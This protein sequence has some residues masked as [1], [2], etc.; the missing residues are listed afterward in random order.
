MTS[1]LAIDPGNK[2][3]AFYL[4]DAPAYGNGISDPFYDENENYCARWRAFGK[5]PNEKLLDRLSWSP[6]CGPKAVAIE[7][8]ASYG[9]PVGREVF[10]TCVWI[11]RFAQKLDYKPVHLV[12]RRDVKLHL[13]SNARA[14]DGNIR[15]A[16][17]DRYGGKE[18]AIGTKK[19]PGPLYGVAADVWSALAIA[20]TW[21]DLNARKEAA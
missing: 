10:E 3:S 5:W 14:K 11:G 9:M 6:G 2:E 19:A 20:V 16:L 17:I 15:Q 8:I 7:M 21:S 13:C 12:Y 18:K 1:V 4:Y